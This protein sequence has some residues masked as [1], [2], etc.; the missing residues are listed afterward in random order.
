M[1]NVVGKVLLIIVVVLLALFAYK[2]MK[3]PSASTTVSVN[4]LDQQVLDRKEEV[5][6]TEQ[7]IKEYLLNNP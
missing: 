6:K 1:H 5:E 2:T 7:I 3:T 4:T